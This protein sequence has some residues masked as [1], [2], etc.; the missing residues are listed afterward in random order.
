MRIYRNLL[1][2]R[3]FYSKRA[4]F[5][6]LDA[7]EQRSKREIDVRVGDENEAYVSV[8]A[9]VGNA[10]KRACMHSGAPADT[11]PLIWNCN[12]SNFASTW[13]D[14]SSEAADTIVPG[15]SPVSK[16]FSPSRPTL[17]HPE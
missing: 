13:Y 8:S 14:G 4:M 17:Q 11:K 15:T 12:K 3:T 5:V 9:D 1:L 10:V 16:S 7:Q 2:H 6:T